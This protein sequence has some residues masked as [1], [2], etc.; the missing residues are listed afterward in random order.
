MPTFFIIKNIRA[1]DL[2]FNRKL[3]LYLFEH[4]LKCKISIT[5]YSILMRNSESDPYSENK[6]WHQNF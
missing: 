6:T 1:F 5:Q 2:I 3:N 4:Y